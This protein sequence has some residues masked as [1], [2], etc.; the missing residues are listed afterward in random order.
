M[1][2]TTTE[3]P[4]GEHDAHHPGLGFYIGIWFALLCLTSLIF[5]VTRVTPPQYHLPASILIA[6]I[7]ASLVAM[8]FMH[9]RWASG[10]MRLT[11]IMSVGFVVLLMVGVLADVHTRFPLTN[12]PESELAG[13][14]VSERNIQAREAYGPTPP[15]MPVEHE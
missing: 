12:S 6:T 15:E 11:L 3:K 7:K 2:S 14:D 5:I 13:K 4:H 10:T 8:F 1:A 9:L